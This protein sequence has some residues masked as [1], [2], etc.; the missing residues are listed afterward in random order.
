[1]KPKLTKAFGMIRDND[2]FKFNNTKIQ[3]EYMFIT[4]FQYV[5]LLFIFYIFFLCVAEC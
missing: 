5:Q 3:L 2:P 1:M 4:L